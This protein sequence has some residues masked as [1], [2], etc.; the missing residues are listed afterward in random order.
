MADAPEELDNLNT[1]LLL[2]L[3]SSAT[4]FGH[5]AKEAV[6]LYTEV[7]NGYDHTPQSCANMQKLT[8]TTEK[9]MHKAR[10]GQ[11]AIDRAVQKE[12]A[13]GEI[14]TDLHNEQVQMM[15]DREER[16]RKLAN[17]KKKAVSERHVVFGQDVP[18]DS[19]PSPPS[20][21]ASRTRAMSRASS[22]WSHTTSDFQHTRAGRS[23]S[24]E[25]SDLDDDT[26]PLHPR[27]HSPAQNSELLSSTQ[28]S[29]ITGSRK[30]WRAESTTCRFLLRNLQQLLLQ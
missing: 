14:M 15:L 1:G 9:A 19:S 28:I 27:V 2:F 30:N 4:D 26:T 18:G 24:T 12:L 3:S 20:Q 11:I 25:M 17:E 23:Q 5:H 16:A 10:S 22:S 29:C 7:L 6:R 8:H 13:S 21:K